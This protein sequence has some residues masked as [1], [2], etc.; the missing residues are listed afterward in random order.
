M[1]CQVCI[2]CVCTMSILYWPFFPAP[3]V[4]LK[5]KQNIGSDEKT[6]YYNLS[7][8]CSVTQ[9]CPHV[10][11]HGTLFVAPWTAPYQAF[12]SLTISWSLLKPMSIE[13]E[14]PSNHLIH[15]RPLLAYL[16]FSFLRCVDQLSTPLITSWFQSKCTN[17][18]KMLEFSLTSWGLQSG[19]PFQPQ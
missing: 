4:W 6:L 2:V 1:C 17:E 13:P 9:S 18:S 14:V 7:F 3:M 16:S 10:Y 15:C 12:L 19:E 5:R 8:G 11:G